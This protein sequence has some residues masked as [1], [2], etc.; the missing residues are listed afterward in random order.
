MTDPQIKLIKPKQVIVVNRSL[1]MPPGKLAAQVA[2][3]SIN[4]LLSTS[5]P[6]GEGVIGLPA[7]RES[8]QGRWLR[9]KFTKLVVYVKSEEKLLRTFE[10]AKAAGLPCSLILDEGLTFFDKPTYTTVGVGPA[11]SDQF[12]GITSG[13][14]LL[15]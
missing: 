15:D 14:R 11:W 8:A 6:I 1:N 7:L 4:A 12:I 9:E 3:A 13:L 5:A 10:K 2:H